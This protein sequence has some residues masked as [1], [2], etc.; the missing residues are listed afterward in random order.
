MTLEMMRH[1]A[2]SC[3]IEAMNN[4]IKTNKCPFVDSKRDYMF[5]EKKELWIPGIPELRG[6]ELLKALC[7]E[8][9]YKLED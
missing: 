2:E 5:Q 9:G 1:D 7:K 8:K 6:M 3:G 4:W